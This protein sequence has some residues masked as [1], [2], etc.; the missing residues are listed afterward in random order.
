MILFLQLFLAHILGDFVLQFNPWVNSKQKKKLRSPWLYIHILLH[1]ALIMLI[2]W[3]MNFLLP[4][5]IIMASHLI[6]D[7]AR[8]YLPSKKRN[9]TFF[10]LDQLLHMAVL[11]AVVVWWE[12]ISLIKAGNFILTP[13]L[14]IYSIGFLFVTSPASVIVRVVVSRWYE[15]AK[16]SDDDS[17]QNAGS[18]I[19]MLE[20]LFIVIFVLTGH[21]EGIGFLIAAKSIFRFA[22]IKGHPNRKLTE[23][24]LIGTLLSFGL[25][26]TTGLVILFLISTGI[27]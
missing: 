3:D 11:A 4:T 18:Y 9:I 20:R 10:A 22:D 8:L 12:E 24:F 1:G 14:L 17:L 2:V 26:M 27:S 15:A 13:Q 7:I 21:W 5:L 19:G 16:T 6:I 23:Y 25:A